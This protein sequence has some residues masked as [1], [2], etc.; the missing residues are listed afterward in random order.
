MVDSVQQGMELAK[1]ASSMQRQTFG[2]QVVTKTLQ[3]MN[4]NQY[5]SADSDYEFQTR[6][7][8]AAFSGRGSLVNMKV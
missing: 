8:S 6:V 3:H 7:L 2:A 1:Q 4:Q 5:G